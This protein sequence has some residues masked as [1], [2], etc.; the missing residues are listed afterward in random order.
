ML[1]PVTY[2]A[3]PRRPRPWTRRRDL[4]GV[5]DVDVAAE[6]IVAGVA[7]DGAKEMPDE[8]LPT[9][10][11]PELAIVVVAVEDAWMPEL[12]RSTRMSPLLTIVVPPSP[13]V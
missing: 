1:M 12:H 3:R 4:A 8:A 13:R 5:Q 9:S 6:A 10:I 2:V 11:R 7:R